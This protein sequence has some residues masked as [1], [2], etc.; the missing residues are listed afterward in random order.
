VTP[1]LTVLLPTLG[2]DTLGRAI[3]SV[4]CQT[5]ECELAV[6]V[7]LRGEGAGPMLNRLLERVTTPWVSTF[8]DDDTLE[9]H[10]AEMLAAQDQA[11]DLIVFQMRY[12]GGCVLP[13]VTD[14]AWLRFGEVGCSYA[15]KTSVARRYGW[16]A[17][18]CTNNL[19]EDWE[20][21][22]SVRDNGGVIRIVPEVAYRVRH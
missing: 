16:I 21:I 4:R 7:D 10:F 18:P 20:M 5:V 12:A 11:A 9:P 17:E 3:Q 22:R 14:P 19:A 8:A 1:L 13:T 6:E 2:R 15:V